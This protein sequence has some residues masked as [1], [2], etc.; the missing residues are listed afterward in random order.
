MKRFRFSLQAVHYVR[1][2]KREVAERALATTASELRDAQAQ[3]ETVQ[4][5]RQSAID[6]YLLLQQA[7]EIDAAAFGSYTAY[8]DS[9]GELERQVRAA[10]HQIDGRIAGRRLALIEALRETETTATLRERQRER[11]HLASAQHEQKL[12]D[13]MAVIAVARRRA[14]SE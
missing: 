14:A 8:I 3:L 1:E 2:I 11:H 9:L 4:G 13:E 7:Q 12:L 5:Q 6:K 10:I